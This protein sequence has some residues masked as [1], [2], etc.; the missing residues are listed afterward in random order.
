MEKSE[1][2]GW[3]NFCSRKKQEQRILLRDYTKGNG[4]I[5]YDGRK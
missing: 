2:K 5:E 4:V 3:Y 1:D